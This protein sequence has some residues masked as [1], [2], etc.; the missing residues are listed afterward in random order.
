MGCARNH[1]LVFSKANIALE[2]GRFQEKVIYDRH[3]INKK[4][5]PAGV[6]V[7]SHDH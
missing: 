2:E 6:F 7:A 3:S 5:D 4:E 1:L